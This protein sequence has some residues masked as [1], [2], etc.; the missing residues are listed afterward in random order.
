M[1]PSHMTHMNPTPPLAYFTTPPHSSSPLLSYLRQAVSKE[2][3]RLLKHLGVD[4]K[5]VSPNIGLEQEFF[6][7]PRALPAL[8]PTTYGLLRSLA[9]RCASLLH[10]ARR[11]HDRE[12]FVRR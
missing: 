2:A 8:E 4:A 7:V 5:T 11:A 3:T 9:L 1:T 6:L 12:P 10:R